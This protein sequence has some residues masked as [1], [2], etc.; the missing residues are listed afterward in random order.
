MRHCVPL[1]DQDRQLVIVKD[2]EL[3]KAISNRKQVEVSLVNSPRDLHLAQAERQISKEKNGHRREGTKGALVMFQFV[4]WE[5]VQVG[6][7]QRMQS[8]GEL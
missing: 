5:T 6:S 3:V 8:F 7:Q 2:N 1:Q 4:K